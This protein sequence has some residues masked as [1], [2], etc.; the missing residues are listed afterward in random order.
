MAIR[1]IMGIAVI[2][3][4]VFAAEGKAIEGAKAMKVKWAGLDANFKDESVDLKELREKDQALVDDGIMD[5]RM[6]LKLKELEEKD[7]AVVRQQQYQ[8]DEA[9]VENPKGRMDNPRD[10]K[11][12]L[13]KDK[14]V[15]RKQQQD[16]EDEV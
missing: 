6:G 14:A 10:L 7:E 11:E 8:K 15:L 4:V 9:L 13:E 1:H 5:E 3:A 16:E 12:L 2:L